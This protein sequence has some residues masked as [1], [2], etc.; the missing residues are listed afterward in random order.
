MVVCMNV[1]WIDIK[2]YWQNKKLELKIPYFKYLL[3]IIIPF[4]AL[5]IIIFKCFYSQYYLNEGLVTERN[6]LIINVNPKD[7]NKIL[8][9]EKIL[10]A[11]QTYLY[12]VTNISEKYLYQEGIIYQT[13]NLKI[14]LDKSINLKNYNTKIRILVARKR[15]INILLELIKGGEND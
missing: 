2:D 13:L 9:H 10:I 6:N 14:N 3:L 7:L 5:M 8:Q 11:N 15:L 12:K 4:F 1:N